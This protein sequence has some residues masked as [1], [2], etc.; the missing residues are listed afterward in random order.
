M[1]IKKVLIGSIYF[2]FAFIGSLLYGIIGSIFFKIIA[3]YEEWIYIV[4]I[5]ARQWRRYPKRS[6]EKFIDDKV[7][8]VFTKNPFIDTKNTAAGLKKKYRSQFFP[9]IGILGTTI[10]ALT[11]LPFRIF[12]GMIEGPAILM[13]KAYKIWLI[14]ITKSMSL[15][16]YYAILLKNEHAFESQQEGKI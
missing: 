6:Y 3:T 13:K 10:I 1:T 2:P 12:S 14:N 11:F 16:E 9:L 7:A 4:H 8:K 5:E 15:D